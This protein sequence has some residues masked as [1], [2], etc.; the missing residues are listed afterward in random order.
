MSKKDLV[1]KKGKGEARIGP[2]CHGV[3]EVV[4]LKGKGV[5]WDDSELPSLPD[6]PSLQIW[7]I[8]V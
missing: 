8:S 5:S 6:K 3:I 7:F 4:V 2:A 1:G